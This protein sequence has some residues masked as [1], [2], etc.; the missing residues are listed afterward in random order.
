MGVNGTEE[1]IHNLA[2]E[3]E[4]EAVINRIKIK[5]E[6]I[7]SVDSSGRIP[8]HWAVSKGHKELVSW[9]LSQ[10]NDVNPKDDSNWTPLII[11]ASGGHTEIVRM[12]LDAGADA[13]AQTDQKRSA[14]LYAASKNRTDILNILVAHRVDVN[15][16]DVVGQTP[17]HRAAGPGHMES[18]SIL[19]STDNC[20]V[21]VQDRYGNTALH[22]A[23]E[24]E[25]LQVA[26][27]LIKAGANTEIQ[28]RE[29]K[30]PAQLC[31]PGFVKSLSASM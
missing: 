3:G 4:M 18:V 27:L 14:L 30:T 29:E 10:H 13:C 22:Y 9:L 17:L 6:L 12:L 24:E 2:L 23:C 1:S 8:L 5:P 31:G 26:K 11:A 16:Q 20:L 21:D 15:Q 19:L 25:R 28:N 7:K